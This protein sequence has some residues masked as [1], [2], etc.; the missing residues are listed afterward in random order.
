[1]FLE[2]IYI[3][4]C[5]CVYVCVYVYVK[6]IEEKQQ[7]KCLPFQDQKQQIYPSQR[8][9]RALDRFSLHWRGDWPFTTPD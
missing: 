5:V 9:E 4:V 2:Y 6:E 3:Y 8:F 1:M 7:K